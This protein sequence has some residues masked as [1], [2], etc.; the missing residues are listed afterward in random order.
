MA[1]LVDTWVVVV[2]CKNEAS[3]M[4]ISIIMYHHYDH[5]EE[6][7]LKEKSKSSSIDNAVG[8]EIVCK[9]K[10]KQAIYWLLLLYRSIDYVKN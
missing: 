3:N 2:E 6:K 9:T 7:R 10:N 4:F 1:A 5:Q 8:E